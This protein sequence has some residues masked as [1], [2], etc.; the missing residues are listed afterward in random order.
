MTKGERIKARRRSLH[1][2][3][4]D[5]ALLMGISKQRLYKYENDIVKNIPTAIIE[6]LSHCLKCT[7]AYLM[8]WE[9]YKEL[10]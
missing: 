3:Q 4:I 8:G 1:L 9:E 5:L 7:P 2:K 10:K 6:K